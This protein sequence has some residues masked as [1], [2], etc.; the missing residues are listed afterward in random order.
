[1]EAI[2]WAQLFVAIAGVVVAA[3]GAAVAVWFGFINRQDR[4]FDKLGRQ[5]ETYETRNEND[6][7]D[8]GKRIEDVRTELRQDNAELRQDNA[9]IRKTL[10]AVDRNVTLLVGRQQE[11]DARGQQPGDPPPD[12]AP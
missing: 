5:I 10:Q 12:P 3:F 4:A 1:M 8:L 6:H 2:T 9:E 11:R 7:R